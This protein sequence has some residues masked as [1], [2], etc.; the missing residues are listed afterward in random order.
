MYHT[1]FIHSSVN[2]YLGCFHDL[3]VINSVA[4]SI[5]G[6]CVCVCVCVCV[7]LCEL[8]FFSEYMPSSRI[9][10]HI[11][12][13]S[14]WKAHSVGDPS[15]S[16]L[17]G[18]LGAGVGL[19][20]TLNQS[21][22]YHFR[23][24][25]LGGLKGLHRCVQGGAGPGVSPWERAMLARHQRL[26]EQWWPSRGSWFSKLTSALSL[27]TPHHLVRGFRLTR[28]SEMGELTMSLS[29]DNFTAAEEVLN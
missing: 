9:A 12:A 1:F 8:W 3:G 10:G 16:G 20:W 19:S 14:F 21:Q 26:K 25:A 28:A 29:L 15:S 23:S 24:C 5:G 4:M 27:P 11:V 17:V 6:V 22:V 18:S 13:L 7:Y 2:G